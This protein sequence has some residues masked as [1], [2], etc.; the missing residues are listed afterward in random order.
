MRKLALPILILGLA[1]VSTAWAAGGS[2]DAAPPPAT[3]KAATTPAATLP[4]APKAATTVPT[5]PTVTAPATAATPAIESELAELRALLHAQAAEIE[6]Q[7]RELAEMKTKM[8]AVKDEAV[9][10]A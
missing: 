8:G 1:T 4:D 2:G 5:A 3:D 10:A 6:A 7:R 9:T